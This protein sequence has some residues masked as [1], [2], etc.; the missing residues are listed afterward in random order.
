MRV[1]YIP[2]ISDSLSSH[3]SSCAGFLDLPRNPFPEFCLVL[4]VPILLPR[5]P[6]QQLLGQLSHAT[7]SQKHS[8][9]KA[10]LPSDPS[11]NLITN[12]R[13]PLQSP[14][15]NALRLPPE[16]R[17]ENLRKSIAEPLGTLCEDSPKQAS[18]ILRTPGF[19]QS[20]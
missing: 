2:Q 6:M 17:C 7:R 16:T 12:N 14:S 15:V 11:W 5:D 1:A 18:K 9:S 13:R 8:K 3:I 19:P 10:S 20:D 4:R